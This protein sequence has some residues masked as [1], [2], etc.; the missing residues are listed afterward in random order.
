MKDI[1]LRLKSGREFHFSCESYKIITSKYDGSL[2]DFSYKGGKGECPIYFMVNDVEAIS[3]I[4]EDK[5]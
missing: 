2:A 1:I 4:T 5:E 3:I